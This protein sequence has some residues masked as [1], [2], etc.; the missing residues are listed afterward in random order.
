[1]TKAQWLAA[2]AAR[3]AKEMHA[4]G[5]IKASLVKKVRWINHATDGDQHELVADQLQVTVT[6]HLHK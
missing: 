6:R 4:K 1:M 5:V 2:R 3:D